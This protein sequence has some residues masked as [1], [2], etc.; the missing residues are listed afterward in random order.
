MS[1]GGRSV[2]WSDRERAKIVEAARKLP[3]AARAGPFA[4]YFKA[5]MRDAVPMSRWRAAGIYATNPYMAWFKGPSGWTG[6]GNKGESPANAGVAEAPQPEITE[7]DGEAKPPYHFRSPLY[8]NLPPSLTFPPARREP[9]EA[10][11][12]VATSRDDDPLRGVA[13]DRLAAAL[14]ARLTA[15]AA[16]VAVAVDLSEVNARLDDFA[17]QVAEIKEAVGVLLQQMGV[18]LPWAP[19]PP[20]EEAPGRVEAPRE[21]PPVAPPEP[22]S[23]DVAEP[24]VPPRRP[25]PP[26]VMVVGVLPRQRDDIRAGVHGVELVF[27]PRTNPSQKD[28]KSADYVVISR[29]ASHSAYETAEHTIGR[30]RVRRL[31]S[32]GLGL[33]VQT[34]NELAA[35][36]AL[37]AAAVA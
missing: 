4:T 11:E 28:F 21:E 12:I 10:A 7:D 37:E 20:V 16:P 26:R 9:D 25:R 18:P 24:P 6:P 1:R 8:S 29:H 3:D 36:Y 15:P 27:S 31:H 22:P 33:I 35:E 17:T 32:S 30:N 2:Q 23:G 19:I 34:I 13:T 5:A 14:F